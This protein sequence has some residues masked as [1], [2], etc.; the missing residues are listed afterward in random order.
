M[1]GETKPAKRVI[2]EMGMGNAL[3]S[4]DYTRAAKRAVEDA[5][6]HSYLPVFQSLDMDP[7]AMEVTLTLAAQEP[8]RIDLDAVAA[9]LPY[10]QVTAKA[11]KG[12][13][14]VGDGNGGLCIIVNA[15]VEVRLR[16]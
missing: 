5:I 6:R 13:L 14:D 16:V 7:E 11:V 10:G 12:G 1:S 9:V 8:E 15:A 3:R 4:G 2:L